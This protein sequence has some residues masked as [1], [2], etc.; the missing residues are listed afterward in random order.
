MEPTVDGGTTG[1]GAAISSRLGVAAA[2]WSGFGARCERIAKPAAKQRRTKAPET[3]TKGLKRR[4][5]LFGSVLPG[6]MVC[7]DQPDPE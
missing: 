5:V 4:T 1:D 3:N 2:D 7:T 6:L